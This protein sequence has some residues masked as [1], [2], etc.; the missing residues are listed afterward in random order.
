MFLFLVMRSRTTEKG[1]KTIENNPT[2]RRGRLRAKKNAANGLTGCGLSI[3]ANKRSEDLS[4][5]AKL[6]G[7]RKLPNNRIIV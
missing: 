2:R 3:R 4:A 5:V 6:T 7:N 1:S